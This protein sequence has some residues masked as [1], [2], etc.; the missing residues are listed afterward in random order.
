M[1]DTKTRF[2]PSSIILKRFL[3]FQFFELW[4]SIPV[5]LTGRWRNAYKRKPSLPKECTEHWGNMFEQASIEDNR[6][7]IKALETNWD[8]LR[9]IEYS[10]IR[11]ALRR[12]GNS[13]PGLDGVTP[14]ALG[15]RNAQSLRALLNIMLVLET[16]PN[17]LAIARVVLIPKC[18]NPM[19]PPSDYRPISISPVVVRCFN[20]ILPERW[21]NSLLRLN[22]QMA[23]LKRDGC[24]DANVILDTTLKQAQRKCQ[25]TAICSVDDIAKAFDSITHDTIKRV[26]SIYGAPDPL[27]NYTAISAYKKAKVRIGNKIYS[28]N[29][30]V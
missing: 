12:I 29:K 11:K 1:T 18:E 4:G 27:V 17:H 9:P 20:G 3:N 19:L 8:F 23:F 6:P 30:G 14:K 24:F 7:V 25:N 13:A 15:R 22:S 21:S 26:A 16:T 5:S 10:E 28:V 2:T